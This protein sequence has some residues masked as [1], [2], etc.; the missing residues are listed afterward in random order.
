MRN[1]LVRKGLVLGIIILFVGAGVAG[2]SFQNR[3]LG[4][5]AEERTTVTFDLVKTCMIEMDFS[6]PE[7]LEHGEYVAIELDDSSYPVSKP[8]EPMIPCVHKV[9]TFPLGTKILNIDLSYLKIEETTVDK[10]IVPAQKPLPLDRKKHDMEVFED[11]EIYEHD[12]LY[13]SDWVSYHT[14]GGLHNGEHVTFLSLHIYPV[15]YSPKNNVLLFIKDASITIDYRLPRELFITGDDYDLL[16]IAPRRFSADLQPLIDH[17][18][19]LNP[20][21][22]TVLVTTEDIYATYS[23]K[24]KAEQIKYCIKDAIE[25]WGIDYVLLIGGLKSFFSCNPDNEE[26]WHVPARYSHLDLDGFPEPKYLCDLYFADIYDA[27]GDFCS[28][29]SNDNGVFGEWRW[30]G[31]Y[32]VIDER[33]LCPDVGFGRLPCRNNLEVMIMVNKIKNYEA[34]NHTEEGWFKTMLLV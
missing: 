34:K 4:N 32:Q 15:R 3:E 14:S 17:K 7:I 29:D 1:G 18:N 24:D 31:G 21:I 13:P 26:N 2:S 27:N 30:E 28:W 22:R 12:E 5:H 33:D 20:P 25:K 9:L 6:V 19:N 23:G 16:L 8:G 11:K 10:K